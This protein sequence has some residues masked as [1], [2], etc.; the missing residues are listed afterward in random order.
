M[1]SELTWW[2]SLCLGNDITITL[3]FVHWY[4]NGSILYTRCL[5]VCV[6]IYIYI[7]TYVCLYIYIYI[8][9]Y[10]YIGL[11]KWLICI[12]VC[13]CKPLLFQKYHL[14]FV[15]TQ[16]N[17]LSHSV[18]LCFNQ[19]HITKEKEIYPFSAHFCCRN[20]KWQLHVST[21]K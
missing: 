11:Y 15:S 19:I 10:I 1:C 5:Y 21:M 17:S 12:H 3:R 18:A 7:F 9:I 6:C 20:Y 4:L 2:L 8:H 16:Q 14:K 13:V